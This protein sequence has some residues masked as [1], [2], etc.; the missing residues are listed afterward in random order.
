MKVTTTDFAKVGDRM[1]VARRALKLNQI[2]FHDKY[3]GSER[4]KL[5]TYQRAETGANEAGMMLIESFVRAGINANWLLT[6]EG[7]ML[8]A[9]LEPARMDLSEDELDT[10][11][12]RELKAQM[13]VER[14]LGRDAPARDRYAMTERTLEYLKA[15]Q[16][17]DPR[18]E[19]QEIL[20]NVGDYVKFVELLREFDT[21]D[22]RLGLDD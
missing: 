22:Q 19:E 9:D 3:V 5:R 7:P 18:L 17:I 1:R 15:L 12:P 21:R 8:L 20:L 2:E 6:G 13:A 14:V 4:I 11:A 10:M 16:A